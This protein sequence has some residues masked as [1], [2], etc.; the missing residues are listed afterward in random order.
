MNFQKRFRHPSSEAQTAG[1]EM[2]GEVMRKNSGAGGEVDAQRRCI[3]NIHIYILYVYLFIYSNYLFISI[4]LK[5]D[6]G[7]D[8]DEACKY[9][10]VIT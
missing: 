6:E 7:G 9:S 8:K 3:Y 4:L 10:K 1:D 5:K 2:V